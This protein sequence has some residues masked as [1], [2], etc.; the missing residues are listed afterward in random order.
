MK[1]FNAI[2]LIFTFFVVSI[3]LSKAQN[4]NIRFNQIGFYPN[5]QKIAVWVGDKQDAFFILDENKRDTVLK[6]KLS[7]QRVNA[8]SQKTTQ[9]ADFSEIKKVGKYVVA[10]PNVGVSYAFEIKS[11]IH[12][13]VAIASLKAFYYQRV[14]TELP[15]KFA[16]KWHRKAGHPDDKVLI[17]ASAATAQRPE[18]MLISSQKV[19]TMQAIIINIS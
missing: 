3:P 11:N 10:I 16:G 2:T 12:R 17:H 9:I 8:I 7:A 6:G 18:G 19:G 5:A 14:S 13:E 15:E 4:S 1:I